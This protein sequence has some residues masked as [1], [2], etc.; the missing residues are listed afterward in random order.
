MKFTILLFALLLVVSCRPEKIELISF[1]DNFYEKCFIDS[2]KH[3]YYIVTG[4][5][6]YSESNKKKIDSL[7]LKK[8]NNKKYMTVSLYKEGWNFSRKDFGQNYEPFGNEWESYLG[9]Y[10]YCA[11]KIENKKILKKKLYDTRK[12]IELNGKKLN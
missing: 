4:K 5:D 9:D 1:P 2:S 10:R 6:L 12:L 7:V 11:Y 8:L 3:L